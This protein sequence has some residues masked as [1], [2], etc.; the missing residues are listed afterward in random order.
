MN[1]IKT[2][3]EVT[4]IGGHY[5]RMKYVQT[6]K[7]S[8]YVVTSTGRLDVVTTDD[9]KNATRVFRMFSVELLDDEL[10]PQTGETK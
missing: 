5:V 8:R 7:A 1:K 2:L 9:L 6:S 10:L 3:A 4:I